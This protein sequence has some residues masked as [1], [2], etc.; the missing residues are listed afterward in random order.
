[1]SQGFD[2]PDRKRV[3]PA[4]SPKPQGART[5]PMEPR[6][7]HFS[8]RERRNG[9]WRSPYPLSKGMTRREIAQTFA[10]C[11]AAVVV[12]ILLLDLLGWAVGHFQKGWW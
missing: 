7:I 5:Q 10:V 4:N 9:E 6:G 12:G 2:M 3:R 1:M 11:L 8:K